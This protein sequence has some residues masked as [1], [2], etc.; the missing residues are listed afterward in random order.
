VVVFDLD[1]TLVMRSADIAAA[2]NYRWEKISES[3]PIS[4]SL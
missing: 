2:V 1:G 3:A 4:T